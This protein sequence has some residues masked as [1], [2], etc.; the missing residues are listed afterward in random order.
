[1]SSQIVFDN[2]RSRFG[3]KTASG[4]EKLI[5]NMCL[6]YNLNYEKEAYEKVGQLMYADK[7]QRTLIQK[8]INEGNIGS[9]SC[10][11]KQYKDKKEIE[12]ER[13]IN[14]PD[15]K[16]GSFKCSRCKSQKT[17]FY[18]LQTRSAD[19]PM[20]NFITCSNCGKHW[21]E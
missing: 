7:S 9:K 4:Y 8:D 21:K 6:K 12:N 2:L 18:Q 5:Q 17:W 10:F 11:F 20:T 19:E 1:M 3:E 14:P 15:V 13:V 16:E